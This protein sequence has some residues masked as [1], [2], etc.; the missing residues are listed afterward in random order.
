M[1]D[2]YNN[3]EIRKA[4][5]L[6]AISTDTDTN[7]IAI[8][9]TGFDSIVFSLACTARTDGT[10]TM[11]IEESDDNSTW[12]DVP[13]ARIQGT[14][15]ALD[16]ANEHDKIGAIV[17]MKY[18]RLVVTTASTSSGLSVIGHAVLGNAQK[19]PVATHVVTG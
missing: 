19:A 2:L 15:T 8:D 3:I 12:S 1:K 4:L 11:S 14:A 17:G 10:A 6:S 18:A 5:D 7:G 13:S 9:C 16:A